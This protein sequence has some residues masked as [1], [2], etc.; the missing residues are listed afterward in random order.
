MSNELEVTAETVITIKMSGEYAKKLE[1]SLGSL[2]D[3]APHPSSR[4]TQLVNTGVI[5]NVAA[6]RL[7]LIQATE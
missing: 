6:L 2:L 4:Y 3:A 7:A 5:D 1:R